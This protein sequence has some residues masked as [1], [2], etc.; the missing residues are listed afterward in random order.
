M[1]TQVRLKN[2]LFRLAD[3]VNSESM[4]NTERMIPANSLQFSQFNSI[5]KVETLS[6]MPYLLFIC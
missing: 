3:K 6:K 5:H 2:S 4:C 1:N